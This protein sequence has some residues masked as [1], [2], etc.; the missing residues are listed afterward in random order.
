MTVHA[1]SM[2]NHLESGTSLQS[3]FAPQPVRY[4]G[5]N[6]LHLLPEHLSFKD[7][8]ICHDLRTNYVQC[9]RY[10]GMILMKNVRF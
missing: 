9:L 10:Q 6:V 1:F 5:L 7:T 3:L 4:C 8:K 2:H